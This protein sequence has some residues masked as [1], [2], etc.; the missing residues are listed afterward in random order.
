M[1]RDATVRLK[2]VAGPCR[3]A[4]EPCRSSAAP[5]NFNS[6]IALTR[7]L[8]DGRRTVIAAQQHRSEM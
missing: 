5:R 7:C 8:L 6:P 1:R 2:R 4:A 3:D